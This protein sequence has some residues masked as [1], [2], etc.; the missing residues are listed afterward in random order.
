MRRLLPDTLGGRIVL[1]LL[2]G[3]LVFHL[4]SLWLHQSGAEAVIGTARE[5]QLAERLAGAKRAVAELPAAD[6]DR[7]A[8]A[9]SSAALDMHWT[10]SP[11]VR[12]T[13]EVSP[14]VE[15]VRARLLELEPNLADAG[16]RLGYLDE[17]GNGAPTGEQGRHLLVGALQLPD[18]SWLNFAAALFRPIVADHGTLLP[19]T[20]STT[21]MAAGIL[22]LGFL[23]VRLIGRP[24][25]ALSVA[26]DRIGRPGET[27]P[28]PED[29]PREVRQAAQAFNRMQARIDRLIADRTQALAAVSH[30]LRTPIARLRLRA[31]FIEDADTQRQI[32]ADLDEMEAMIASTLAYLRGEAEQEPLRVADLAAILETLCDD[33]TDAGHRASYDGPS[34]ARLACRPIAMKRALANLIGNAVKYGGVARVSLR[35]SG[36]AVEIAVEDDGPGIPDEELEAAFEPFR[37]LD[38]ARNPESGG[39]GLG[40]T[41]ARQV[42][43]RHGGTVSLRNHPSGG[44]VAT[45]TIPRVDGRK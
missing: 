36:T 32:D 11:T 14:R 24:L 44:L 26:A 18:G 2:V 29:G 5:H 42:A 27:A 25:R 10:A 35:D 7:M 3:L 20:L 40:L 19:T 23:V 12:L 22:V 9:L 4:G 43:E 45:L 6:R 17:T 16:M 34:Q 15:A 41:I 8:H 13:D 38:P 31:G 37:R 28:V 39:S 21:V 1:V 33:A 30:D